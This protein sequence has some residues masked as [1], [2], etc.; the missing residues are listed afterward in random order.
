MT[1]RQTP[2]RTQAVVVAGCIAAVSL[3]VRLVTAFTTTATLDELLDSPVHGGCRSPIDLADGFPPL[4]RVALVCTGLSH[5]DLNLTRA[6]V[7]LATAAGI[8]VLAL[9]VHQAWGRW[10]AIAT[11]GVLALSPAA[12][13]AGYLARPYGFEFLGA[14]LVVAGLVR[15]VVLGRGR[16]CW[17]AGAVIC[18]TSTYPS[19]L[20]TVIT[21]A[22]IV[23]ACRADV[24][25]AP[26]S[27]AAIAVVLAVTGVGMLASGRHD[28]G[29]QESMSNVTV[30]TDEKVLA[31]T[32]L[33][34]VTG[35]AMPTDLADLGEDT[36]SDQVAVLAALLIGAVCAY[37]VLAW[38][39]RRDGAAAVAL[40]SSIPIVLGVAF[41]G[42]ILAGIDV[43][44]RHYYHLVVPLAALIGLGT[45]RWRSTTT[46]RA[47][48]GVL[49]TVVA[50][51]AGLRVTGRGAP[52]ED[53]R[54]AAHDIEQLAGPEDEVYVV[55]GFMTL[56]LDHYLSADD[57]PTMWGVASADDLEGFATWLASPPGDDSDCDLWI[58][59]SK[60]TVP[61]PDERLLALMEAPEAEGRGY[62]IRR[63][64]TCRATTWEPPVAP[65]T[66]GAPAS[67]QGISARS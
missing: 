49:L 13:D 64:G 20:L 35:P 24:R 58:V 51:S 43:R 26:R 14:C 52:P 33:T 59:A 28:F 22:G 65:T 4:H 23:W 62:S 60:L 67:E 2:P 40:A 5:V 17:V 48:V 63:A 61:D 31:V 18:L 6:I 25:R 42:A 3:V 7:A 15:V 12:I 8:G 39:R 55:A 47:A 50:L 11:G 45:A 36:P 37:G 1:G 66:L 27:W 38:S 44:P 56:P 32:A 29:Y 19:W 16:A 41:A 57:R 53:M 10:A 21:G 9:T 30:Q 46:T 54:A 34:V